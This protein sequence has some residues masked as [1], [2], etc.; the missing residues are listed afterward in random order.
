MV[1]GHWCLS[2]VT[3]RPAGFAETGHSSD[4]ENHPT[5]LRAAGRSKLPAF[6][7]RSL[8]RHLGGANGRGGFDIH[9]HG[10]FQIDEVIGA[11]SEEG[12]P[13]MGA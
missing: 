7:H 12:L 1:V 9:N 6:G 10:V 4:R 11:V 13:A 2:Q 5:Y 8:R 3:H